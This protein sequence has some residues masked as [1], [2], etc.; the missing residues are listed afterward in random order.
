MKY[1]TYLQL[2]VWTVNYQYNNNNVK[3][4]LTAIAII[5]MVVGANA[6]EAKE[7]GELQKV[8]EVGSSKSILYTNA[9]QWASANDP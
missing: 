6:Q 2:Y 8:I 9:Q 4:L 5:G 7:L 1:K 3:K